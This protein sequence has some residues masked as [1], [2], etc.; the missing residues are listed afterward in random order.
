MSSQKLYLNGNR[1]TQSSTYENKYPA[2]NAVNG[3][4]DFNHTNSNPEEWWQ[5]E[6]DPNTVV[7]QI[8]IKNRVDQC[9]ERL[10]NF[11]VMLYDQAV[12]NCLHAVTSAAK[13]KEHRLN[14]EKVFTFYVPNVT[15]RYLRV[16]LVGRNYLHM[17]D[18]SAY[19]YT[20]GPSVTTS[21]VS[22]G[23][24][25]FSVS[26]GGTT[27]SPPAQT[28]YPPTSYPPTSY[29]PS[30]YGSQ[31]SYP[32]PSY[33][34]P[35]PQPVQS[36]PPPTVV[37][38]GYTQPPPMSGGY[39]PM[40]QQQTTFVQSF[41]NVT[42]TSTSSGY[43][44]TGYTQPPP[45]V[46]SV[47]C[48]RCQGK[49]GIGTFGPCE[50]GN[51]HFKSTCPVCVGSRKYHGGPACPKCNGLGGT[52]TFGPCD[53]S[54][55]HYKGPCRTCNGSCYF[56]PGTNFRQCTGCGG[57]GGIGKFGPCDLSNMHYTHDCGSCS[58]RGYYL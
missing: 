31:P 33:G 19:G 17:A 16:Q 47:T 24:G 7:T 6:L 30:P 38:T 42:I 50:P 5:V 36:Y 52:G 49:G 12:D 8:I 37:Q 58:G 10:S 14:S 34:Q 11:W 1:C 20:S 15:A 56:T 46:A 53:S 41:P 25:P 39:P 54:N 2:S 18:V 35:Y 44:Q 4:D 32:P 21:G 29:P 45:V 28:G 22:F 57:K 3:N 26:F 40:H 51:M 27:T 55:M 23:L 43:T 48:P 13:W 9:Q